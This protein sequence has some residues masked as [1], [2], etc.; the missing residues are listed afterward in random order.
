MIK[1]KFCNREFGTEIACN[2]HTQA[3]HADITETPIESRCES[4]L[5]IL[6]DLPDGAFF[7]AAREIFGVEPEDFVR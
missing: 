4:A 5:E 3:K 2:Q 1:C 7:E 6:G